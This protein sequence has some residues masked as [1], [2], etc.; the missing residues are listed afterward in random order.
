MDLDSDPKS[1]L[2]QGQSTTELVIENTGADVITDLRQ[3]ASM[4][5]AAQQAHIAA[6]QVAKAQDECVENSGVDGLTH[7]DGHAP[8]DLL[9]QAAGLVK[10]PKVAALALRCEVVAS[11]LFRL[12]TYVFLRIIPG[13]FGIYAVHFFTLYLAAWCTY[14]LYL[15][16]HRQ[17]TENTPRVHVSPTKIFTSLLLGRSTR[18][19]RV[20]QLLLG[21]QTI[22]FLWFLDAYYAPYMFPSYR[23]DS[24]RFARIGALTPSSA[25]LHVRY[26]TPLPGLDGF[27]ET[28][29]DGALQ[30]ASNFQGTPVRV[31]WRQAPDMAE[32]GEKT[33]PRVS[34]MFR[35]TRRWERGPLL[36]LNETADWT[37]TAV[38]KDLWPA[39]RY[40]WRLAFVHNN[41]F[42]PLPERPV[43]FVTWPDPR[44]SAYLKTKS[45]KDANHAPLD[46]PNHFTFATFSCVKPDFP[47]HPAQFWGWNWL[48]KLV[49][50]GG[51][52]GGI[53]QRN[54]WRMFA[55]DSDLIYADVPRYEGPFIET[56]RKLYRNLFASASFRRVYSK[57]PIIGIYD[58][59]EIINNWS[60]GGYGDE[61]EPVDSKQ[62]REYEAQPSP[63]QGLES[64]LQA[65]EEY[66]G[67][68][69]PSPNVAG[70]HFFN[71]QYGDTAF[72]VM[73]TRKHRV[74]PSYKG[75]IRS[76]L[77]LRQRT[78][79]LS[80]LA[81]VNGTATFK[82][83]ISSVPFTS[84]WGGPLDFDGRKDG[85]SAYPEERKLIMDVIQY[86]PNVIILSGDRHE[87]ASVSFRNASV[88]FS[89]SPLSM[90]YIPVRTLAQSHSMDPPGDEQLL[91]YLPDGNHKWTELEVD[92]RYPE[93][94]V[95]R[96]G[97]FVDGK[98][99][100]H[101][102]VHG[103]PLLESQNV[104]RLAQSVERQ[105]LKRVSSITKGS[106]ECRGFEP[107]VGSFFLFW[108]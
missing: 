29:L 17:R 56:Y 32:G 95:V 31:V 96:V 34:S 11:F 4:L 97:V 49:G 104:S 37:A 26:P 107:H 1:S 87:F 23:E 70:D 84:L 53:A 33:A 92:T 103:R 15:G 39:T 24:L 88:E 51:G 52:E 108:V 36:R 68:A 74:H 101:L 78:A 22:V 82:F 67:N 81:Q 105:T 93:E 55:D 13:R 66:V 42:A 16:L 99:A 77:G 73:D 3:T 41:T 76:T 83:L 62:A 47:Y 6:S 35:D 14:E 28:E 65:W 5:V 54:R 59:H 10:E 71:F 90:F 69:N 8:K 40:E 20:N 79:L 9:H 64:G 57:I 25:T 60:G 46:D 18:S 100:W 63:P 21:L 2:L 19:T 89:T 43:Q 61:S 98:E 106:S 38:L 48:L 86:V 50:I 12:I 80:W 44:L 30:D 27:W 72:F 75:P 85:W 102:D 94:P 91:K 58:D 45:S 7:P